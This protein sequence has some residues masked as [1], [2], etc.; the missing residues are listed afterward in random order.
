MGDP[1]STTNEQLYGVYS[2][3]AELNGVHVNALTKQTG[4]ME[5]VRAENQ[6]LADKKST[7]D[8]AVENQKGLFISMIIAENY[9]QPG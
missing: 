4:I 8:Q 5:M 6:R 2:N 3:L 7:I 1:L 9:L